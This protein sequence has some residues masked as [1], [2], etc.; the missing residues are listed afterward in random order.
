MKWNYLQG[1][2]FSNKM[3]KCDFS[4][5]WMN[6]TRARSLAFFHHW[7]SPKNGA[8]Y[9]YSVIKCAVEATTTSRQMTK[10]INTRALFLR[11]LWLITI[12][13]NDFF[14]LSMLF[15]GHNVPFLVPFASFDRRKFNLCVMCNVFNFWF[16]FLQFPFNFM[17]KKQTLFAVP[18][19]W[20][21]HSNW[22]RLQMERKLRF[23]TSSL[24][25]RTRNKRARKSGLNKKNHI[26][27]GWLI[28]LLLRKENYF[29]F[30]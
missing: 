29:I 16:A 10:F 13:T 15:S 2:R 3:K 18:F 21:N 26:V 20:C 28:L 4:S 9:I 30:C 6:R 1:S 25:Y 17:E 5:K 22:K 19:E 23:F 7:K 12:S 14:S 8:K 11:C 27:D 24:I